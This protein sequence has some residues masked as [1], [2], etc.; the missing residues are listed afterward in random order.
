MREILQVDKLSKTFRLS[1]K[2]QR[3]E[4]T[5]QKTKKAVDKLSFSRVRGRN[6]W[7]IGA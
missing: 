3:L 6:F 2:Q 5:V 7:P 1:A 4:K